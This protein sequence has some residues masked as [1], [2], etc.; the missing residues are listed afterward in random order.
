LIFIPGK[1]SPA[2]LEELIREAAAIGEEGERIAFLSGKFLGVPYRES[3]L[4][5]NKSRSEVLVVNLSG[6]DCFTL[7]D[8]VEAM[9]LSG[10]FAELSE[11][12]ER[13]R[14][15]S[16]TISFGTRNHFFTDWAE[17]NREFIED[18]TET[19][20]GQNARTKRKVLNR[21]EDGSEF[22]SGIPPIEREISCIPS[23]A[24]DEAKMKQLAT[25]DYAG[26][27]SSLA[28]LDV[29]HVGII[30]KK[31]GAV[32]LRHAS[33]RYGRVMDEEF[34]SYMADMPGMIVLRPRR[35]AGR[36]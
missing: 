2:E 22:V 13:V 34:A 17:Y 36:L 24:P 33:K 12:L 30:I 14:Y 11:N 7:L 6:V 28:G 15:H 29:S 10:S 3:T 16:G 9:R 23:E 26:I 32:Y 4:I 19:I 35:P 20:G 27:C 1:F 18:V 8:Y 5:G 21:K 31:R 25:G